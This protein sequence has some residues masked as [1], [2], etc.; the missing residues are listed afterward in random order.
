[1]DKV[2]SQG[3]KHFYGSIL[4]LRKK[5]NRWGWVGIGLSF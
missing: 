5:W 4:V 3:T 1:M 2:T